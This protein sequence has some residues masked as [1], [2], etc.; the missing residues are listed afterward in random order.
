MASH[1]ALLHR[2]RRRSGPGTLIHE[3]GHMAA[4]WPD[5]YSYIAGTGTWG[6][7][8][9]GYCDLPNPYFCTKTAGWTGKTSWA[10]RTEDHELHGSA[11]CLLL[12]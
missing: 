6:I 10:T 5:T 8:A 7:M 2:Y 11:F 4:E 3:H 1:R 9:G 12:L